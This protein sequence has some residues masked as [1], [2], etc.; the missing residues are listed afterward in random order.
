VQVLSPG[1]VWPS[2]HTSSE[3]VVVFGEF[4]VPPLKFF[5][6]FLFRTLPEITHCSTLTFSD[7]YRSDLLR[8]GSPSFFFFF[9]GPHERF[10]GLARYLLTSLFDSAFPVLVLRQTWT[11]SDS[12]RFPL[13]YPTPSEFR[14]F[15]PRC[16]LLCSLKCRAQPIG[17]CCRTLIAIWWGQLLFFLFLFSPVF[18]ECLCKVF[19]AVLNCKILLR[20]VFF[21]FPRLRIFRQI[22]SATWC[23]YFLFLRELRLTS[24]PPPPD[25]FFSLPVVF[26]SRCSS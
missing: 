19:E 7:R 14:S 8:G 11:V 26:S 18:L 9:P 4:L 23:A 15:C 21:F 25:S 5:I 20:A 2:V 13:T 3:N 16:D 22:V 10:S 1:T 17:A 24:S 6:V 12:F